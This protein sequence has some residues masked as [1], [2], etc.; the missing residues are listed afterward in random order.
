MRRQKRNR[1][2]NQQLAP[3]IRGPNWN[4]VAGQSQSELRRIT[5]S[6][7][8]TTAGTGLV[9]FTVGSTLLRASGVEWAFYAARFT[10]YRIL[11]VRI[12]A[13]DTPVAG[14]VNSQG[15][16][17]IATDNS[18]SATPPTTVALIWGMAKPKVFNIDQTTPK[19]IEYSARAI[20]LEDMNFT[21]VGTAASTFQVFV[22]GSSGATTNIAY[23]FIEWAVEFRSTQ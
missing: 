15:P 3:L 9:S 14:V 21:P 10:E 1:K 16:L 5:Y 7:I 19:G 11:G 12:H 22:F 18:G 4:K 6:Q 8:L 17:L 23:L 13:T 20:D 2:S